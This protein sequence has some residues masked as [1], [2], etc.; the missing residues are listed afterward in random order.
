MALPFDE[1]EL[2]VVSEMP[3]TPTRGPIAIFNYPVTQKE[4]Y[5]LAYKKEPVWQLTGLDTR[6]FSPA[7]YPDNVARAFAFEGI[8]FDNRENGGGPDMFGIEWEYVPVVGG[9]IVKPGEPLFR[10]ANEWKSKLTR[11]DM[12]KWDWAGSAEGNKEYLDSPNWINCWLLNG[13][14]ERLISFMDFEDAA[15]ALIDDDQKDAVKEL[16]EWLTDIYIELVDYFIE[17]FPQINGFYVHDDWASQKSTFF[18]PE[19]ANEML[20][21]AIKRFVAHLHSKGY[22]VELHSC[23]N[24]EKQV[25]NFIEMGFDSWTPMSRINTT[26]EYYEKYGDKIMLGVAADA[27]PEGCTDD[28]ARAAAQNYV[29]RFCKPGAPSVLNGDSSSLLGNAAFREELYKASRIAYNG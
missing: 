20:V 16:M 13:W 18:A 29:A 1:K 14:F 8:P 5:G 28:E 11:P 4:A 24:N 22:P 17:Y 7:V 3:A 26:Q 19:V 27:L 23:G 10:D 21:P 6:I 9:S 2:E 15:V 12:S 25:E